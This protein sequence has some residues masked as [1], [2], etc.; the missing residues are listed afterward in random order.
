MRGR[1]TDAVVVALEPELLRRPQRAPVGEGIELF[2]DDLGLG[3]EDV[4]ADV[5]DP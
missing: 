2:P 3:E 5:A 4:D 1:L